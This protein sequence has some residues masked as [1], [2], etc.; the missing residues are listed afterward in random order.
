MIVDVK[1]QSLGIYYEFNR[2]FQTVTLKM[3]LYQK[4]INNLKYNRLG[5]T[6]IFG[7]FS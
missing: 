1:K 3:N 7:N 4:V 5:A 2:H 6:M